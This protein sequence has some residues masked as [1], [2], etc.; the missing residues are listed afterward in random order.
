MYL[1]QFN[2]FKIKFMSMN[3]YLQILKIP[4][5]F[6]KLGFPNLVF[7]VIYLAY[8]LIF[9][10][11]NLAIDLNL[12]TIISRI[13]Y[14]IISLNVFIQLII[15][16]TGNNRKLRSIGVISVLFI[17]ISLSGYRHTSNIEFDY[18]VAVD[19]IQEVGN[20]E[21]FDIIIASIGL[22]NIVI[23]FLLLTLLII[24]E[25]KS[26][27][28]SSI[29]INT[30]LYLKSVVLMI[31]YLIIIILPFQTCD[32]VAGL[33]KSVYFHYTYERQI[34]ED[35]I[36]DKTINKYP[37]VKNI[38]EKNY[39]NIKSGDNISPNIF[40]LILESYN[41]KFIEKKSDT[42]I[43]F[44]PVFN[45]LIRQGVYVEK[46]YA[47]SVQTCKG[48]AAIFLSLVPSI[49]GKIYRRFENVKFRS[50]P[51]ILQIKG[52]STI[53]FQGNSNLSMDNTK[54]FLIKNGFNKIET[55]Y[56]FLSKKEKNDARG[57]GPED[58]VVFE[59]FFTFLDNYKKETN[60]NKP[61]FAAI[62]PIF[63]H[64][65][66]NEVPQNKRYLYKNP[67]NFFE[68]YTNSLYLSDMALDI[69]FQELETRKYFDNSIIIITSDHSY[70]S[71]IHGIE[72]NEA[73]F[74]NESFTI[75]FLIIWK[76]KI[77]PMRINEKIFSQVD[78]APS[79]IDLLKMSGA[80]ENHFIGRS[81]FSNSENDRP[82]FLVQPYSGIYL[83][84]VRFPYRYIKHEL[85]GNE[86]FFNLIQD[87]LENLNLIKSADKKNLD[88]FRNDM[89]YFY[90]QQRLLIEDRVSPR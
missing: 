50:L 27:L 61:I 25:I 41:S 31:I 57:F 79:I 81:I 36:P 38:I 71:G 10:F 32:P 1:Y 55:T 39:I 65:Y 26:K 64:M 82:I 59:K 58:S 14:G 52:Y 56:S 73:G 30:P 5:K 90:F 19:N 45:K 44:T 74:Y 80:I 76:G 67:R 87:P 75:P 51:E 54:E 12:L 63:H 29:K 7:T 9:I 4:Q 34:P 46:F 40:L 84:I 23:L 60:K 89:K 72:R 83:S 42:G 33:L 78:I 62:A 22:H 88:I 15:T 28:I 66:F 13:I 43:E 49:H 37:L 11:H 8:T 53:F 48:H 17:I 16:I 70:P 86:Y 85:T 3:N 68:N 20:S 77:K 69:F 18:T 2:I 6:F 24:A 21:A 47:N 35:S